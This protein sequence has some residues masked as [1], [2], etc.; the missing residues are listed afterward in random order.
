MSTLCPQSIVAKFKQ[1]NQT[2][3]QSS[4]L[5]Q[6]HSCFLTCC[7]RFRILQLT[8]SLYIKTSQLI[9]LWIFQTDRFILYTLYHHPVFFIKQ[10]QADLLFHLNALSICG[11]CCRKLKENGTSVFYGLSQWSSK[12]SW[13]C[14]FCNLGKLDIF[15]KERKINWTLQLTVTKLK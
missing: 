13:A 2:L 3:F 9:Y 15:R 14:I 10:S 6:C 11:I 7:S 12:K 1:I 5:C 4:H 8:V